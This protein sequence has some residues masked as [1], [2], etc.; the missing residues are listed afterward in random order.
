MPFTLCQVLADRCLNEPI[1]ASFF[2]SL[3][4]VLADGRVAS[5]VYGAEHL[6]RL[7]V[8]L[9]ELLAVAVATEQQAA[10]VAIMVQVRDLSLTPS[11]LRKSLFLLQSLSL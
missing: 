5:C 11:C 7:I 6:L 10:G 8:K 2:L 3:P 1:H 4:Q 9:P